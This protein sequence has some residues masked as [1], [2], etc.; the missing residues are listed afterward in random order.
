MS[1]PNTINHWINNTAIATAG[2]PTYSKLNP[3]TGEVIAQVTK[4]TAA[5]VDMAIQAAVAAYPAWRAL[6]VIQRAELLRAA[7]QLIQ[8]RKS[9]IAEIVHLETGKSKKD[10]TAEAGAAME[11]GFFVAGEGRRFYGKTTTSAMPN[12]TAMIV[13]QPIGVCGLIIA[14]NTPLPNV[15][16][17]AFPALLCGNTAVMKP[18]EDI[19]YTAIWFAQILK[20]VGV[21]AGV[22]N[23]VQGF[24]QD[25]G[26]PLVADPRVDVVSFTGSVPV[27]KQINKV[28][29][30]RLAK[31]CL[32]LGG[33]N[34]FVVCDDADLDVAADFAVASAFSNAGQRC[35][36]GSRLIV[37]ASVYEEFKKKLLERVNKLKIGNTDDCDFGPVVNERYL[38]NMTAA[39]ER[40]VKAGATTLTGGQRLTDSEH[41]GGFYYA[42]TILENATPMAEVSREELFGPITILY[43]VTN[44]SEALELANS[45]PFA[46]TSAIH[47]KSIHRSQ[48]FMDKCVAGVVSVNGPS[49]G[50]EPHMPFGGL[51][52]SGTGW[53]EAGT[54]ALDVYSEWKTIYIKHNP[55]LV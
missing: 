12:R 39:V 3:A 5:D 36:A 7:A 23:V 55:N 54:E 40:A 20:E 22:F 44:F 45:T 13:R 17:K 6:S 32:E 41:V 27:G 42:P 33:K 28:A 48:E 9:E 38:N 26:A 30:E 31:V 25:V 19:P 8:Q 35:A 34:P 51:K 47:T 53:R 16:W 21:P 18:S 14:A 4:G 43:Q 37:F 52:N 50:S 10:A 49:H 2:G 11:M 24:G 46:L 29:A 1:Y 15:A